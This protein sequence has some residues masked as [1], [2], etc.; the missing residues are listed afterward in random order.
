MTVH[1]I[2]QTD[3]CIVSLN[4][5]IYHCVILWFI[6]YLNANITQK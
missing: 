5:I 4:L 3:D 1:E 6:F 2:G